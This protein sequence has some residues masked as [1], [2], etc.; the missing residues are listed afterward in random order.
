MGS[1][2]EFS[3]GGCT[4]VLVQETNYPH[5]G[6]IKFTVKKGG[7]FTLA[8]RV[9]GWCGGMDGAKNGYMYY[10]KDWAD[11]EELAVEFPMD[12]K[13]MRANVNVRANAGKVAVTRGPLVYCA[14]EADNGANLAALRI[15]CGNAK[16]ADGVIKVNGR[17]D[18][19]SDTSLYYSADD[20]FENAEITLVP[21]N[22]WGNRGLGEM[23][24]WLR[25]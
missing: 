1:K 23:M 3:V 11:G 24:V 19:S 25:I 9:P 10:T 16:Y 12:V 13:F 21:Y 2:A 14:E 18:V 5:D 8:L 4:I 6:K 15:Y 7:R 22:S 20:V 17:R